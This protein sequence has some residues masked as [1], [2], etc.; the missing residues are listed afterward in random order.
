MKERNEK[1][2]PD[3]G[4]NGDNVVQVRIAKSKKCDPGKKINRSTIIDI[5]KN[6]IIIVQC[7]LQSNRISFKSDFFIINPISFDSPINF[8]WQSNAINFSKKI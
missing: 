2:L 6:P 5:P 1:N 7:F 4:T 8:N 3:M